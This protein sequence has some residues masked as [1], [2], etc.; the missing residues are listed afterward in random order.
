MGTINVKVDASLLA[1]LLKPN[2][3]YEAC[4]ELIDFLNGF[5]GEDE[6]WHLGDLAISFSEVPAD[7]AS[8]YKEDCII[9]WLKNGNIIV[10]N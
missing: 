1:D 7:Y 8:D 10:T 6:S 3:T 9:A 2:F 4:E 5:C